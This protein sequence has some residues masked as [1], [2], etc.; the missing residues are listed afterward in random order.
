MPVLGFRSGLIKKIS[1][2]NL[3]LLKSV[4]YK[5]SE[6]TGNFFCRWAIRLFMAGYL[7]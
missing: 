2:N 5:I 6:K 4:K 7:Q 3:Y 1:K